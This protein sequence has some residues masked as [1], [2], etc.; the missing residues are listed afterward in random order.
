MVDLIK[1]RETRRIFTRSA[2]NDI[3]AMDEH[4]VL[5][6]LGLGSG[7]PKAHHEGRE[8]TDRNQPEAEFTL[9]R[10]LATGTDCKNRS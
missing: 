4:L 1:L 10:D 7:H 6:S 5:A 2:V 9:Y 8:S 3:V